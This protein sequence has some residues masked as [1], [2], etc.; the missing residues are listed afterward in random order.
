M[1]KFFL[2]FF[3]N[4]CACVE[5]FLLSLCTCKRYIIKYYMHVVSLQVLLLMGELQR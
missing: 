1:K 5:N 4:S 2:H 3:L